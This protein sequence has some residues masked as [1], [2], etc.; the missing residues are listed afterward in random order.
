MTG[1]AMELVRRAASLTLG[2]MIE[3]SIAFWPDRIA[4]ESDRGCLTYAELGERS[5]RACAL[6][7][8]HGLRRGDRFA[9][10]SENRNEYLELLVAAARM[11]AIA[12]CQNW[13]LSDREL[14]HCITLVEPS[15]VFASERFLERVV[16]LGIAAK[17]RLVGFGPAYET[18]L[19]AVEAKAPAAEPDPEDGVVILYTSGTTGLPKAALISQRAE[20]ARAS[21]MGMDL[22]SAAD[23]AFVAWAPLFHMVSTDPSF[24]AFL[25]GAKVIVMNGFDASRLARVTVEEKLGHLVLMPGMIT[26]FL[27]ALEALKRPV[28]GVHWVGV[29][30]D[31]VPRAQLQQITTLLDAPYLN[32]FGSTETG[33]PPGSGGHIRIGENP[34][35]LDKT[36]SALCR[37]RLVDADDRDVGIGEV[38]ELA[39]R[40]SCLFSG[41]WN[42]D[43]A[44][45][46]DFRGG[47]FHMGD[48]FRR[49][50]DGTL[51]FVDR[52]KY[53]IKSGGENIYP[54]EVE[55]ALMMSPKVADAVVVRQ[56]DDRWGEVPVAFIV[57]KAQTLTEAEVIDICAGHIARYK[58]P[59][60]VIFVDD[61]DLPR[62]TTGKIIR[63]ELEAA[64]AS[65]KFDG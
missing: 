60:R 32:S 20:I 47:W 27:E 11:G 48:V 44:T 65:G 6:L 33:S 40:T 59:R 15:V 49:N 55:Q 19:E 46:H 58:R 18:A 50:A 8:S 25:R 14:A 3:Q 37:I 5:A 56:A 10:V 52:R 63:H 54:A 35:S 38:G 26:P 4:V 43:A 16:T 36:K 34:E 45:L 28:R 17:D 12:C 9:I 29:M 7:A 13:R 2:G 62:S 24:A 23:E 64:L 41:Y 30:A 57:R 1:T 39:I 31:L 22:P 51:T 61:A 21:V 42:D 53:L